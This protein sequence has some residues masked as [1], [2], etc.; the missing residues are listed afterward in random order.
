MRLEE[1]VDGALSSLP[2]VGVA[3][4]T[5]AEQPPARADALGLVERA[6]EA[7]AIAE[8][9]GCAVAVAFEQLRKS[10]RREPPHLVQPPRQGEVMERDHRKDAPLAARVEHASV[11]AEGRPRELA[12]RRLDAGPLDAEAKRVE[13]EIGQHRDVFPVAVIEVAG[14]ARGL[15][16]G[17]GGDVLPPP[18]IGV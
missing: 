10:I 8:R 17:R 4:W 3:G 2:V 9:D 7:D 11:V 12:L 1:V 13:A 6:G 15:P 14:I 5:D 18:P 16:A